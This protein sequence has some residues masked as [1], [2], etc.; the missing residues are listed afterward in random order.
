MSG[1]SSSRSLVLSSRALVPSFVGLLA[2]VASGCVTYRAHIRVEPDGGLQVTEQ[3]ELM[4]GIADTLHIQPRLAWTAFQ[5]ATETR[6]GKFTKANPDTT[7]ISPSVTAR[8]PLD[9]WTELGQRG[10]AF[11]GIDEVEHRTLPPAASIQVKDQYF[12]KDTDLSYHV[13]LSEP[14][15]AAMDS[16]A[17]PLVERARGTLELEVP[18]QVLKVSKSGTRQGNVVSWALTY[19]QTVDAE[20]V[21]RQFEW[22]PVVSV[23]L[24]AIFL[25][26]L[27]M[28][29]I[30]AMKARPKKPKAR[31]A[32]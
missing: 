9:D 2:L 6:G 16:L 32:A 25:G 4:P 30:K 17:K 31:P 8:Y 27:L 5:A 11:K 19:G 28:A 20:V 21:Y 14:A 3:A 13:S 10:Q 15:G 12:Y 7:V 1:K 24:V 22:V 26:Y 18:G 29:G 23:V